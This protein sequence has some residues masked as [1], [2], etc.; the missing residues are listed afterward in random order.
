METNFTR[1]TQG[2][3]FKSFVAHGVS[4]LA[5]TVALQIGS[6][7]SAYAQSQTAQSQNAAKAAPEIEEVVVTGSRLITD[8]LKAPTP[9]TV[10]SSESLQ[11]ATPG[12]FVMALEQL[13]QFANSLHAGTSTLSVTGGSDGNLN[14]R[15][16]GSQRTL[17]LIDGQR[18]AASGISGIPDIS[19]MPKALIQRTDVI[20]GGASAAYGSDAV[21]GV[22]NFVIDNKFTGVKG[23]LQ[24][25][26]TQY[27]DK[28]NYSLNLAAG[29][30]FSDD[31][32][33]ITL[34][35]EMDND[36]GLLLFDRSIGYEGWALINSAS[37][38]AANPASPTNPIRILA[39]GVVANNA[40][41][42]G[43]ITSSPLKDTQFG[44][45][46]S[47]EPY[48]GGTQRTPLSMIGG[49]G[50]NGGDQTGLFAPL[51]SKGFYAYLSYDVLDSL[52]LY[53][54][55][56][57]GSRHIR[58]D[59]TPNR[60]N[61]TQSL[62][63]F[64]DNAYLPA[65][66][67][68]AMQTRGITSFQMARLQYDTGLVYG[69]NNRK[70]ERYV[71]GANGELGSW[72]FDTYYAHDDAEQMVYTFADTIME[73]AF[74]AS[75]AVFNPNGNGTIICRTTITNPTDG[76]VP[77]NYFGQGSVSE[78]AIKYITGTE[79]D[80][81]ISRQDAVGASLRGH[82]FT[83]WAGDLGMA[84]GAEYRNAHARLT[85]DAIAASRMNAAKSRAIP[86]VLDGKLG[87]Y[88]LT[89]QQPQKGGYSVK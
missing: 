12:S 40:T 25:G 50:R 74:M 14:L 3:Q 72:S 10:V 18:T 52:T 69:Q 53:T 29:M 70:A 26:I 73:N 78:S 66:I 31:R 54:D 39:S 68:A 19:S 82:P 84:F 56:S 60:L 35:Y 2:A 89:N 43:V 30:G 80:R 23:E 63:I 32:G 71:A 36:E 81:L 7:A 59:E 61:S 67:K 62:T 83:L 21:A 75:D 20:T 64:A 51:R 42:G 16:I 76:C 57:L 44:P 85:P 6:T 45:G 34:S 77:A 9:V 15:G 47:V 1:R 22:V 86:T 17:V 37:V 79:I 38:T 13:P 33:H 48:I 87:G 65:S 27:G 4:G 24:G 58:V 8:G 5:L 88:A 55:V 46:G 28:K 41:A 49:S 11:D